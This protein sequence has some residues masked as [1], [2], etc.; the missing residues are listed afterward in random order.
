MARRKINWDNV[1]K[2]IQESE[3]K[4]VYKTND[5]YSENLYTPK[6]NED[7]SFQ[8][9]I[10][11][12]PRPEKDGDGVPYVKLMNHGFQEVGGWYIEN[13]PT[14]L[15]E[16]CPVC[17]SNSKDWKAG[18]QDIASARGRRTSFYANILVVQDPQT[19]ENN[20]KVFIFRYGKKIQEKILEKIA[21]AVDSIDEPVR[22]FDYDEG[23]NF[24]LK[25][26]K[27]TATIRGQERKYND[28][29][30]SSFTGTSTAVAKTDK[31]INA[32][33]KQL[34]PLGQISAEDKF[35]SYEVLEKKF[36]EK[37]G[38][39][40]VQETTSIPAPTKKAEP[41]TEKVTA[42]FGSENDS[43]DEFFAKLR[44]ED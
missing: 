25:I 2:K 38:Q 17:I 19:P 35:K 37:T 16:S 12:L 30:A 18:N 42:G 15:G 22:V 36:N 26:K 24:K 14:T 27:I 4:E 13:C 31:E 41:K 1:T 8:A 20:G 3:K 43:D 7:G 40:N 34:F 28:Y 32:I 11:L 44:D 29:N 10:R 5:G 33:D 23:Q 39:T 6:L 21:P 9:I